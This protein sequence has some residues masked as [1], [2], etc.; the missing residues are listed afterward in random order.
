MKILSFDT[1][2]NSLSVAL[3]FDDQVIESR[4]FIDNSKQS[5]ILVPVIEECLR[6]AKIW[7]QDLD[8]IA[9]TVGPGSFTGVRIG[10]AAA[11]ILRLSINKPII[12]LTVFS[13]L[14]Y[15]YRQGIYQNRKYKRILVIIDAKLGEFYIQNFEVDNHKIK[16][17]KEP[18]LADSSQINDLLPKEDFLLCS[19]FENLIDLPENC[20]VANNV[21]V[22]DAAVIAFLAKDIY[23]ESNCPGSIEPLYIRKPKIGG[24]KK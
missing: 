16:P 23:L 11:K 2:N 7:Y 3:V 18:I 20:L 8:L 21:E 19:N 5:E 4:S 12:S 22:I 17:I 1:T 15:K 6:M 14:A 13:A 9:V 24:N 10:I